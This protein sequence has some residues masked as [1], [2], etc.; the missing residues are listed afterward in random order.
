MKKLS[1]LF[2]VTVLLAGFAPVFSQNTETRNLSSFSRVQVGE[3]IEVYL[4]KGTSEKAKIE[5]R[6]IDLDDIVTDVSGDKLRI[7][8][9]RGNHRNIDV[10]IWVNYK[11][12]DA[13]SVSSAATVRTEGVLK[14]EKLRI[15]ASSAGDAILEIDTDVLRVSVSS[16]ADVTISGRA[17]YQDVSVSSAGD[18][19]GYNLKCEEAEVNASS[20]GSAKVF[21]SKRI[22]ARASSAGSIRYRGN[23]D[24]EYVSSSS[25]GSVRG[26]N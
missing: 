18:Y 15:E 6:G 13:V 22:E 10:T 19:H 20:S 1:Y 24:K 7:E 4:V 8:L 5:A 21:A 2:L 11:Y 12:L 3:A 14:S 9:R 26:S 16:S 25:G 23:P 17:L